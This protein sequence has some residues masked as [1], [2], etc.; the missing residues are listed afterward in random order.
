[1]TSSEDSG[2]RQQAIG[3]AMF[4][5]VAFLFALNGSFSQAIITAGIGPVHLTEIRGLLSGA[6]L[7]V[8]LL[9]TRPSSLRITW[10]QVPFLALYG[11]VAF[12]LTQVL[13]MITLTRLPV[14][15]T[16]LLMF[17]APV[18][19][20]LWLRF[21]RREPGSPMIWVALALVVCGLA[22]V[23][24]FWAG[25]SLDGLGLLTGLGTAIALA[26][27]WLLGE[28]G[29]KTRDAASLTFWGFV[30]ATAMWTVVAPW[31]NFP[32]SALGNSGSFVT[33]DLEVPVWALVTWLVVMGT[34][35]PFLLVVASIQRIGSQRA[36][37][38]GTTEPVWA[39]LLAFVL[40][41]QTI[42]GIQAIGGLVVI[43]GII[44]AEL[45]A[46]RAAF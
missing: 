41:G 38:I 46:R 22:L 12:A 26:C 34:I 18:V 24:Q 25:L 21:G 16:T 7:L 10:R 14:G 20:A 17:L 5:V 3:I 45:S 32:W 40:L 19:V 23:A 1:M 35:V 43:S 9:F 2:S 30:F 6:L 31:W 42:T 4:L 8:V 27:Y 37:I 15:I 36:G 28:H 33:G 11:L 44:V 13:Y 29:A 39:T